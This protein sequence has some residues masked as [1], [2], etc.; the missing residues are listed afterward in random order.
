MR[1]LAVSKNDSNLIRRKSA[2]RTVAA[3]TVAALVTAFA[4]GG[5]QAAAVSITDVPFVGGGTLSGSFTINQYGY[6]SGPLT[7]T[8]TAGGVFPGFTY[9]QV[10]P[11]SINAPLDTILTVSEPNY[12]GYLQLEFAHSLELNGFDPLVLAQ[13]YECNG[14]EH[15]DGSCGGTERF[16][17]GGD[18][19]A[20]DGANVPEPATL[21]LFGAGL[22]AFFE[23]ARRRNR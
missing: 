14:F 15:L 16:F 18:F 6:L 17:I 19:A 1:D 2:G 9:T 21:S 13:S 3:A 8:T 12:D 5:A 22:L 23:R 7:L 4:A 11:S 10:D 20:R